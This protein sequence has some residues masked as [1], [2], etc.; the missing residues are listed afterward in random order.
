MGLAGQLL[1]SW[2]PSLFPNER[3][4]EGN[5][6]LQKQCEFS[7]YSPLSLSTST[8]VHPSF[9]QHLLPLLPLSFSQ[10]EKRLKEEYRL[11]RRPGGI[12]ENKLKTGSAAGEGKKPLRNEIHHLSVLD[13]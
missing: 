3:T 7:P 13:C 1:L 8:K 6:C 2:L 10:W 11:S 12:S 9:L 4:L 5:V